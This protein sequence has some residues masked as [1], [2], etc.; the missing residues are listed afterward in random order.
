[1]QPWYSMIKNFDT[2]NRIESWEEIVP[3][4]RTVPPITLKNVQ[5]YEL[6]KQKSKE[7]EQEKKKLDDIISG[8]G[9]GL[10]LID[11][12][13]K[14]VWAN[15]TFQQWF[16]DSN[17][18]EEYCFHAVRQKNTP[19]KNCP[20]EKTF[21]SGTPEQIEMTASRDGK[22][23]HY[24]HTTAPITDNGE[25]THALSL[26]QDIT[27][28]KEAEEKIKIFYKSFVN[29]ND[30]MV[31]TDKE[32][33][34]LDVNPSFERIYKYTREEVLGKNPRILKSEHSTPALYKDMWD[35]LL[36]R[37]YWSGEL[38]NIDK[39]KEEHPVLLSISAIRDETGEITNFV[40]TAVDITE[41]KDAEKRIK[42]LSLFPETNP[43]VV[44]K[45]DGK[46]NVLYMN[47]A[48]QN[49]M[50]TLSVD[51]KEVL[52]KNVHK[53]IKTVIKTGTP[54]TG[55][56][57]QIKGVYMDYTY[58]LFPDKQSVL[59]RGKDITKTKKMEHQ[60]GE[61]SRHLETLVKEK[62]DI[63]KVLYD[64]EYLLKEVSLEEGLDIIKESAEKLGFDQF[65]LLLLDE[66]QKLKH[67]DGTSPVDDAAFS[68]LKK[69][70]P[71]ID[72]TAG[73]AAWYPLV[74]LEKVLGVC[75]FITAKAPKDDLDYLTL[76]ASQVARFIE[77]RKILVEPAVEDVAKGERQYTL[78]HG[79]SYLIKEETPQKSFDIFVDYVTHSVSGLCITRTNPKFL[80]EQYSFKKTPF[81]WL[82]ALKTTEY[83][84]TVDLTE[85]SIS[86][87]DFIK[88]S[89]KSIILLD[90][91]EFLITKSSYGE[92]LSFLQSVTEFIS[93]TES[94]VV[95]PI[96]PQTVE[97]KQLKLLEREMTIFT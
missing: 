42:E 57:K 85:L 20:G 10:C 64:L 49:M 23:K 41:K 74:Y 39:N 97:V 35:S 80:R 31:I 5:L 92:V 59:L 89:K 44:L 82:S 94:I 15:R 90:G 73:I 27:E 3:Q 48:T 12:N 63:L 28:M 91:I 2:G 58:A 4:S 45:L 51:L 86:I 9:A 54:L 93:M 6:A 22:V 70:K 96:S 60:L 52:P 56:E 65:V 36:T 66:E 16:G 69:R 33:T 29:S 67:L 72:K 34:I 61:Y 25:V 24:L 79:F 88:K 55:D 8:I 53:K 77:R 13:K 46:G 87:K 30:M 68:V 84:S 62:T 37:G 1:M 19:C 21:S 18:C 17:N 43:D 50:D 71:V 26:Y 75:G 40:G 78:K 47:P 14:I 38:I 81:I 32:G 11:K 95:I 76:F 83:T 7:I